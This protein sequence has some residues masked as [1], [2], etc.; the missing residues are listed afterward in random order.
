M[1]VLWGVG[2][3]GALC[4]ESDGWTPELEDDENPG[5]INKTL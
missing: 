3:G 1:V 2:V 4:G 5:V